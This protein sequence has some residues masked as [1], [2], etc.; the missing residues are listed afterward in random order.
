M[1]RILSLAAP[2]V[3]LGALAAGPAVAADHEV[4]MLNRGAAGSMVFEPAYLKIR[5]GDTVT[6]VPTDNSHNAESIPAMAPA[7]AAPFKGAMNKPVTVTFEA[8]GIYGYKCAPHYGMGMVGVIEVGDAVSNFDTAKS[9]KHP[10]RAGKIMSDL[11]TRT[12]A[13]VAATK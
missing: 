5:P 3:L 13:K 9:A 11:L 6:F 10:G 12:S 7:G 1:K 2:L 4:K 8:E